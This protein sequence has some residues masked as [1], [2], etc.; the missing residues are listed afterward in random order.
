MKKILIAIIVIAALGGGVYAYVSRPVEAPSQVATETPVE[1]P[2]QEGTVYRI[3]GASTVE[4]R[5]NEVLRDKP[6]TAVGT[7]N[8]ITGEIAIDGDSVTFGEIKVNARTFKT[9]S[10]QRD[11]A[12]ARMI[13]KSESAENEFIVFKPTDVKNMTAQGFTL[14]G[15]LTISGVTKPA[16][17]AVLLGMKG[18]SLAGTATA[19]LKRSDYKLVIPSIPFVASVDDAFT[20]TATVSAQKVQ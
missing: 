5:I 12:I 8:D 17:F 3:G 14:V 6:F 10:Q 16:E 18:D 15:D 19:T 13:L 2:S 20:V 4:F 1:N 7:T 9:D 11:G